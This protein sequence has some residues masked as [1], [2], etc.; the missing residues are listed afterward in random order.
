[1]LSG[2]TI[3][4]H[5]TKAPCN[6]VIGGARELD[7]VL[8]YVMQEDESDIHFFYHGE[9]QTTLFILFPEEVSDA[10]N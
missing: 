4:E 6:V 10:T 1:M 8:D 2:N 7:Q 9:L 3:G 5:M